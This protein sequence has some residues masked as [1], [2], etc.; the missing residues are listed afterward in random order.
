MNPDEPFIRISNVSVTPLGVQI[1]VERIRSEAAAN[2]PIDLTIGPGHQ[3]W[4]RMVAASK[5]LLRERSSLLE[6]NLKLC[7][8]DQRLIWGGFVLAQQFSFTEHSNTN[9]LLGET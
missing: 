3:S 2:R 9:Q 4:P 1:C 6:K 5:L 8:V 7:S